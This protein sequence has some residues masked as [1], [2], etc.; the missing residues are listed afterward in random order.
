MRIHIHPEDVAA[1]RL[2]IRR[3]PEWHKVEHLYLLDHSRC[4]CCEEHEASAPV[5]VH[6]IFPFHYAIALGRPDLELDPR[7]LITLCESE[8]GTEAQNHHLLIGHLDDFQSSNLDVL[9]DATLLYRGMTAKQIRASAC[10]QA[11]VGKR[12]KPLGEMTMAERLAFVKLM[13]TK[14]PRR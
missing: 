1:A 12:L 11:A 9:R 3:S 14:L 2:G 6:H 7:N 4:V 8:N 5:Q 13:N 10:W